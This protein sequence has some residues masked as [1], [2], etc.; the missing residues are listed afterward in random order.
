MPSL[1]RHKRGDTFRAIG[2]Y[3][4]SLNVPVDLTEAEITIRSQ[5]S[6]NGTRYPLIAV[7][8]QPQSDEANTGRFE[9]VADTS[10]WPTGEALWDVEFT[11]PGSPV[12]TIT[13]TPTFPFIVEEDITK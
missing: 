13:S 11:Q 5:V 6:I 7:T 8:L 10:G 9:L 3:E 12:S 2:V 4:D 1:H